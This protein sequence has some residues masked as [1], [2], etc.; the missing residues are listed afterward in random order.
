MS[1][2]GIKF[3]RRVKNYALKKE[4][5]CARVR[6]MDL[7]CPWCETWCSET[8][9]VAD[10]IANDP[11]MQHDKTQCKKCGQWST[12]FDAGMVRILTSPTPAQL[13]ERWRN[14]E[15]SLNP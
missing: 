1:I 2:F 13:S 9:G 3:W 7:K 10:F 11:D 12:W 14:Q 6:H 15:T 8:D 4:R 5:E